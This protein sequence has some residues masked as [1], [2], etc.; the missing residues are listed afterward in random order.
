MLLDAKLLEKNLKKIP[1][2]ENVLPKACAC[3]RSEDDPCPVT[4]RYGR[5]VF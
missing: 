1:E 2:E 5:I 3:R 4:G